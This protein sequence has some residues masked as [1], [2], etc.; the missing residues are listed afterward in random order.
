MWKHG[1][2][3]KKYLEK[4]KKKKSKKL[5]YSSKEYG[6]FLKFDCSEISVIFYIRKKLENKKNTVSSRQK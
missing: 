4:K 2:D 3:F 6:S 1:F 5:V